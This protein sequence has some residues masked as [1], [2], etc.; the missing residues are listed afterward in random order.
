MHCG[1]SWE[2]WPVLDKKQFPDDEIIKILKKLIK[3]E[4]EML[5]KSGGRRDI[6]LYRYHRGLPA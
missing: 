5:E 1:L 3:S 4:K 2:K 6:A